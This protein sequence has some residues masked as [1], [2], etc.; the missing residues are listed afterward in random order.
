MLVDSHCHLDLLNQKDDTPEIS[1]LLAAAR[2][3]GVGRFLCVCVNLPDFPRM[4]GLVLAEPDVYASVGVHPLQPAGASC[5]PD[6]LREFAAHERIVAIGETGLDYH[7]EGCSRA[8]QLERYTSQLRLATE[9][10]LPVIVH[11]RE[12]REDTLACLAEHSDPA[13]GGVLHCF[14]ED[15]DMAERALEIGFYISFSGI[16]TFRNAADLRETARRLP[17]DRVLVETD[18]PYLAPVPH[19]GKTNE[20]QYVCEVAACLAQL[21]GLDVDEIA[22]VTTDNCRRLFGMGL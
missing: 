2:E 5:D 10:R 18:S 14:T 9:L 7:Y 15:L 16:L 3:R 13:V 8:E 12:A 1:V 17:L 22:R 11:T 21:H 4:Q 20:P 6:L 19:R